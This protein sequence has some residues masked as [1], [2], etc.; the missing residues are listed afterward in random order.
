MTWFKGSACMK[1]ANM[2][3]AVVLAVCAGVLC[4]VSAQAGQSE[5]PP[6]TAT[7]AIT[8]EHP[9]LPR[10]YE[11]AAY[12]DCGREKDGGEQTGERIRLVAGTTYVFPEVQGPLADV[13][14]DASAVQYEITGLDA[15]A[16]YILGF[17]WWDAD[18]TG[19]VQSVKFGTGDPVEW[20][21]VLPPVRAVA[22]YQ[23]KPTWAHV[24]LPFTSEFRKDGRLAVSFA[25]EA[26]PNAVVNEMWLLKKA[27]STPRKRVLI[28][29]GDD[30]PGHLWRETAP[31]FGRI[32][33]EDP[34]LEVS[35]TECPAMYASPLMA[36]YD[37][38]MLHFKNY[39]DRLPLGADVGEGL[40]RF[41]ESG[42]GVAIAHFG[43]GAFQKWDGFEQLAGRVWNPELRGHDPYGAFTVRIEDENHPITK[44]MK[45]FDVTDELYTCL[46][47]KPEI[48][49]LCAATSKVDQKI[50]PMAFTVPAFP[51]VFHSLLGHGVASL[52]SEG[53]R[54]LY[55]R[56]AAWAAG[57]E[58]AAP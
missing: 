52:Q 55:R 33:R 56:A 8:I 20:T 48:R 51:K 44:G 46:D 19:R 9:N 2:G 50:Y 53:A 40:A 15:E 27:D 16:E 10:G 3:Y 43:C 45:A 39:A 49:V 34:R 1:S 14:F 17:T 18:N 25:K 41:A 31:E 12:V 4:S 30:Y 21:T 38:T 29:T 6:L 5:E 36:H 11:M 57:L 37:A 24:L 23:D 58:P 22:Y 54:A 26:G 28:V 7:Q 47:G 42:R 32:L 35:V 13:A